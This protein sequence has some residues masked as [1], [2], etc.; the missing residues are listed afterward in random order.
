MDLRLPPLDISAHVSFSSDPTDKA[1][2]CV[3]VLGGKQFNVAVDTLYTSM[4]GV[5]LLCPRTIRWVYF[6][7][8]ADGLG[9]KFNLIMEWRKVSL[10]ISE[11]GGVTKHWIIVSKG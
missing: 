5:E 3:R 10:V 6:C 9:I 1:Y 7:G 2:M 8:L 11:L 4:F